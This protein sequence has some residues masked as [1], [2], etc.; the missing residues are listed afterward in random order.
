MYL[1]L[2]LTPWV[3]MY[4]VSTFVMNHRVWFRGLYGGPP[5]P[6]VLE[7]EM[8]YSA[9]FPGD[10][11]PKQV[12]RQILTSLN[13]DGAFNSS[14]RG[15][16]GAYIIQRIDPITPR[17][18]TYIPSEAKLTIEKLPWES[19]AFL[20]RMHRRRGYQ[21]DEALEDLWAFSVD[22]FIAG[23]LFWILSGLWMWWELRVTR[24]LGGVFALGGIA[25]FGFFLLAI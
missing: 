23:M 7:R 15:R 24:K 5:P 12:A 13:L 11:T 1:A 19:R 9:S 25:L 22:L 18:I 8:N 6:F 16:D 17:R 20:E 10:A 21:H 3:L 14:R 2:F 4:S